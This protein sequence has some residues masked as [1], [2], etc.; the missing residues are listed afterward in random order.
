MAEHDVHYALLIALILTN[1]ACGK[2]PFALRPPLFW[3]GSIFVASSKRLCNTCLHQYER[4]HHS[5]SS[6]C[7]RA[8]QT[9]RTLTDY[10]ERAT[11]H[12][13]CAISATINSA[14][15]SRKLAER[16]TRA[17][18]KLLK[19]VNRG[20]APSRHRSS[21]WLLI[22]DASTQQKNTAVCSSITVSSC[23]RSR[24]HGPHEQH[25]MT[26][27]PSSPSYILLLLHAEFPPCV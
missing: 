12:H 8:D 1:T 16:S 10:P 4:K 2:K 21:S 14:R 18:A 19:G 25:L 20:P 26:S 23:G 11:S 15:P 22:G 27:P 17:A 3:A 24:I 9:S 6:R 13:F 7:I 5:R